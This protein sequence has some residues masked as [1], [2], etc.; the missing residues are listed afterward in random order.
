MNARILA[1]VT[2]VSLLALSGCNGGLRN[3]FFG[4]G[5]ACGA[6]AAAGPQFNIVPPG[7]YAPPMSGCGGQC[8]SGYGGDDCGYGGVSAYAPTTEFP[9]GGAS[10][11]G[12]LPGVGGEYPGRYSH[13]APLPENWVPAGEAVVPGSAYMSEPLTPMVPA[14]Q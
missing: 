12:A 5:A 10:Y 14:G 1:A 2:A 9:Y 4:R 11:G 3:M 13:P 8:G 7:P 6:C